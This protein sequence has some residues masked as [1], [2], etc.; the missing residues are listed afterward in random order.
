[1]L[2]YSMNNLNPPSAQPGFVTQAF[3]LPG[4]KPGKNGN[5]TL[6]SYYHIF[7]HT[8]KAQRT[9]RKTFLKHFVAFVPL[10]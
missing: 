5:L 10:W 7:Y 1:M 2:N 3:G 6:S 8:T 4:Y 9:Q